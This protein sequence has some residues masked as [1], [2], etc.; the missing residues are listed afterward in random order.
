M[1]RC[2][3]VLLVVGAGRVDTA[4]DGRVTMATGTP[5]V[6]T[7]RRRLTVRQLVVVRASRTVVPHDLLLLRLLMLVM[8]MMMMM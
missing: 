5:R 6:E 8:M 7:Q 4:T 3:R 1:P 2:V